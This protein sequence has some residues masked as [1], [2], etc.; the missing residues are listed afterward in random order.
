MDIGGLTERIREIPDPRRAWGNIRHKREDIFVIG[1]ATFL[2]GG[3][4]FEDMEQFG[5]SREQELRQF[6]ELPHGIPDE[7]TFFRVFTRVNSE[8]LGRSV[9][10]WL[11]EAKGGS[12]EAVSIDGKTIRGSKCG[13]RPAVHMVSA[14]AGDKEIVLGQVAVD[15]K[16]NEITAIPRLLELLDIRGATVSIDAMGCQKEIAAGIRKKDAEYVLAVKENQP[17]LYQDIKEYFEG[18]EGGQIKELPDDI[19]ETGEERGHG[20]TEKREVRTVTELS[21]LEGKGEVCVNFATPYAV[22]EQG[23]NFR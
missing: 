9:N 14:W 12:G 6:L 8:A 10:E 19:W 4:D 22:R 5:L 20:R 1:L 17:T 2:C 3:E 21:W 18:M 13:E 11:V 15:E 23:I 7:S 16:S